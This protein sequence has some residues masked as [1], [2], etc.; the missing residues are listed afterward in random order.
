[1]NNKNKRTNQ[2]GFTLIELMIVVAIIG[3]LSAIAVPAYKDYT[4]KSNVIA[5]ISE[6]SPYKIA[7]A[8]CYQETGS[9]GGCDEGL[10][11][12]PSAA[13]KVTGITDGAISLAPNVDCNG[14]GTID[15]FVYGPA[16]SG[17]LMT[18]SLTTDAG[19]CSSYL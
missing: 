2:K 17:G 12:V 9:L 19:N 4:V 16:I 14:N 7:V 18:W 13:S 5:T 10:S 1:M 11:G 15:T 3:V 6:A 8:L